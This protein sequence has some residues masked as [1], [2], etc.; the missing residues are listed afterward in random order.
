MKIIPAIDLK[1]GKCVRLFQGDF[2]QTTE[3]SSN[4][5][6]TSPKLPGSPG[7]QY[8]SAAAYGRETTWK[9]GSRMVWRVALSGVLP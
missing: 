9:P 4:P 3:Y 2:E 8:N 1:D 6:A 5:A 7:W